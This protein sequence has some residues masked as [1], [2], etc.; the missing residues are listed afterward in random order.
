MLKELLAKGFI[1]P[2][3]VSLGLRLCFW[4]R[5]PTAASAW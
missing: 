2:S 1:R 4:S 3:T 5:S